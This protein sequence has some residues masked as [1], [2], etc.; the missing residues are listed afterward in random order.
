MFYYCPCLNPRFC[1]RAKLQHYY[2]CEF[3]ISPS[4]DISYTKVPKKEPSLDANDLLKTK[5]ILALSNLFDSTSEIHVK[6][7]DI[8]N[9][10]IHNILDN[11]AP[12]IAT[13]NDLIK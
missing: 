2:L 1:N 13:I 6:Y 4:S 9:H 7:I 3:I 8:L 10:T 11:E 5:L 12:E